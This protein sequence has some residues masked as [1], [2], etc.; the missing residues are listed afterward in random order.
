M[1]VEQ[2][3]ES[4]HVPDKASTTATLTGNC[5]LSIQIID[6]AHDERGTVACW[7]RDVISVAG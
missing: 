4:L 2:V 5:P 1:T 7:R 6:E 3:A